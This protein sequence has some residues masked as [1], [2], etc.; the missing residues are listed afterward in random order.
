MAELL[1]DENNQIGAPIV[2]QGSNNAGAGSAGNRTAQFSTG[3][4]QSASG[5]PGSRFTNLQKYLDANQGAG[6]RLYQGIGSKIDSEFQKSNTEADKSNKAISEG[7]ANANQT[8]D[9][10]QGF[11]GQTK[12][13]DFNAQDFVA[14]NN[15]QDF[16]RFRTGANVNTSDLRNQRNQALTSTTANVNQ[17]QGRAQ[18][19]A[20]EQGRFSLLQET[21]GGQGTGPR[22][23][24]TSG[25]QR[26]DNLFLQAGGGDNLGKLQDTLRNN[27]MTAQSGLNLAANDYSTGLTDTVSRQS[28]LAGQIQDQTNLLENTYVSDIEK[29]ATDV[30]KMRGGQITDARTGFNDLVNQTNPITQQFANTIGLKN[31]DRLLNIFKDS[32]DIGSYLNIND[33][34]LTSADDLANQ[35][36]GPQDQRAYYGALGQLAGLDPNSY[37]VKK[38]NKVPGAVE[39]ITGDQSLRSRLDKKQKDFS[40]YVA[41]TNYTTTTD[42]ITNRPGALIPGGSTLT[43]VNALTGLDRLKGNLDYASAG[44]QANQLTGGQSFVTGNLGSYVADP[45]DQA[46]IRQLENEQAKFG[47]GASESYYGTQLENILRSYRDYQDKGA[48]QRVKVK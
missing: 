35:L 41:N 43:G 5:G 12:E 34:I 1:D 46:L 23:Q 38:D 19:A 26:L 21:F 48:F 33:R 45:Q 29:T 31:D 20:D 8:L 40:D 24:Y 18:Q 47:S 27:Q 25:Q 28:T 39:A 11:L 14:N 6:T 44:A 30:N 3:A 4:G 9:R 15:V 10:G 42:D 13:K 22:S 36:G 17:A 16:S 2:R 32:N 7:I 37:R